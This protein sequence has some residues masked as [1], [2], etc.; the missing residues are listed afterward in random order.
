MG[1]IWKKSWGFVAF[2]ALATARAPLAQDLTTDAQGK[3]IY[4]PGTGTT[5][6]VAAP[7]ATPTLVYNCAAMPLICENVASYAKKVQNPGGNGDLDELPVFIS[8]LAT[9]IRTNE[10]RLLAAASSTMLVLKTHPLESDQSL[11]SATSLVRGL[12]TTRLAR[13][14]NKITT[15]SWPG[16]TRRRT[17]RECHKPRYLVAFSDKG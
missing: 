5:F 4:D 3:P 10:E 15:Q 8:I 16:P 11:L 7:M 13:S 9:M 1:S 6:S 17:A 14:V 12:L 2:A